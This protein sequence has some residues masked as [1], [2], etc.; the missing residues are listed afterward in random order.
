[1]TGLSTS[2]GCSNLE[3]IWECSRQRGRWGERER[4][5]GRGWTG[6]RPGRFPNNR[7]LRNSIDLAW[8]ITTGRSTLPAAPAGPRN[9]F[10]MRR[11]PAVDVSA[12]R[13]GEY[14]PRADAEFLSSGW[15]RL[16]RS[17][18]FHIMDLLAPQ[19]KI[20]ARESLSF[21]LFMNSL[22]ILSVHQEER[23]PRHGARFA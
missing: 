16:A 18:R 19:Q 23:T 20:G 21:T 10:F 9:M 14:H 22:W 11:P 8:Y 13:H 17:I 3:D 4:M 7:S 15:R 1:M 2:C 5:G 6:G 12:S